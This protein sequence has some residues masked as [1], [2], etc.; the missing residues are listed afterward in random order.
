MCVLADMSRAMAGG[1]GLNI[2]VVVNQNSPDSS[3]LGNYFSELRS[4]PPENNLRISWLG[5]NVSWSSVDFTNNLLTPL[6]TMLAE[7]GLTNQ[8]DYVVL[9]MGIPFQTILNGTNVNSTTSALFYGLKTDGV[10]DVGVTNSFAASES[11]FREAKPA[12]DSGG[13]AMSCHLTPRAR[14]IDG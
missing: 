3:V 2:V 13:W 6:M 14:S 4:I 8:I 10:S 9:S 11:I 1:S 7:R 5:G 12:E